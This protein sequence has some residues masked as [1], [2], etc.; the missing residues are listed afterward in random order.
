MFA[1]FDMN[2]IARGAM[3]QERLAAHVAHV[4]NG[5][6]LQIPAGVI[7]ALVAAA[8]VLL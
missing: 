5:V 2:P 6:R 4:D 1:S 7:V 8:V 3:D